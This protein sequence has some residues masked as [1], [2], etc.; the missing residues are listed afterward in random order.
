MIRGLGIDIIEINRIG[1]AMKASRFMDRI[2]TPREQEYIKSR[3]GN[4]ST[5]AG[6]FA[7]KEAAAKA[8]GTGIGA[9]RWVDI[10]IFRDPKGKPNIQLHGNAK[11]LMIEMGAKDIQVSISH[12]RE[13]AIAQVVI[14]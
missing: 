4:I 2:Y 1:K 11:K 6:Y 9:L 14:C 12:S 3:G 8:L 10:E 13:Y 5:V 7:A